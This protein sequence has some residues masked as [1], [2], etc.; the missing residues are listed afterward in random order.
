MTV[1]R[2]RAAAGETGRPDQRR[3]EEQLEG[4]GAQRGV[5]PEA[6]G[7]KRGSVIVSLTRS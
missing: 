1:P 7:R 4:D 3:G 6:S 2:T 5:P